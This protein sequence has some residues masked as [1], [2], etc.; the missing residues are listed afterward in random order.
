[1]YSLDATIQSPNDK[2]LLESEAEVLNQLISGNVHST[3]C[4]EANDPFV[5]PTNSHSPSVQEITDFLQKIF[6]LC[7]WS[8]ECNIIALVLIARLE[9]SGYPYQRQNWNRVTLCA[10]L[11]AQ[12][13]WVKYF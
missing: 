1:M 11:V 9:N 12:K 8:S 10:L 7:E 3:F 13:I 5:C 6:E 2:Q 4:F